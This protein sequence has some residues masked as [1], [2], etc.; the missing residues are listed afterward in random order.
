MQFAADRM[1]GRLA[2]WLRLLGQD[3]VYGPHLSGRSLMHAA[4]RERRLL[5]TRD[6]RLVDRREC[7]SHLLIESDHF[8]EQLRQVV[9]AV[10]LTGR[11]A[12]LGRC[13]ECNV[14]LCEV[15]RSRVRERVPAYVWDTQRRFT[16]CARCNRVFWGATHIERMRAELAS[17]RITGADIWQ[18]TS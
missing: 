9:A 6:R 13:L 2:R 12:I 17:M 4:R 16:T 1:L 15:D 5:L 14:E 18:K 11:L 8:R 3:V 10:D 7:P